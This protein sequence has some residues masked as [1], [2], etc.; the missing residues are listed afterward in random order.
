MPVQQRMDIPARQFAQALWLLLMEWAQT[1]DSGET[2]RSG[3]G[4][5]LATWAEVER[6]IEGNYH[7]PMSR[8]TVADNLQLPILTAFPSCA[9]SLAAIHFITCWSNA[10]CAKPNSSWKAPSPKS[11]QSRSFAASR[12]RPTSRELLG[13]PTECRRAS[14]GA[15]T[16]NINDLPAHT[17]FPRQIF[18]ENT[19]AISVVTALPSYNYPATPL[20][21]I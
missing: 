4:Q 16:G 5:A 7:R 8:Q 13:A 12:A 3:G 18:T 15:D 20:S 9:V 14:G 1:G 6:I 21:R 17:C 10:A 11:K 19:H 2:P